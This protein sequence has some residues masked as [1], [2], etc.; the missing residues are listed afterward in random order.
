MSSVGQRLAEARRLAGYTPLEASRLSTMPRFIIRRFE[1]GLVKP[2][3][4]DLKC[5]GEVYGC[6]VEFLV[7]VERCYESG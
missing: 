3:R 7:G 1:A 6:S 2:G 4:L 5:L